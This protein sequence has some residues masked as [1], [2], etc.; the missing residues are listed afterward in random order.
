MSLRIL[1][2]RTTESNLESNAE[3]NNLLLGEPYLVTDKGQLAIGTGINTYF[4]VGGGSD[5]VGTKGT[6]NVAD[7]N[8]EWE[9][10]NIQLTAANLLKHKDMTGNAGL[11]LSSNTITHIVRLNSHD[12]TIQSNN[13]T[14]RTRQGHE[15][16]PTE[17]DHLVHKGFVL[18]EINKLPIHETWETATL[19]GDGTHTSTELLNLSANT[20]YAIRYILEGRSSF[21]TTRATFKYIMDLSVYRTSSQSYI[22]SVQIVSYTGVVITGVGGL[23]VSKDLKLGQIRIYPDMN[24]GVWLNRLRIE[25]QT[26]DPVLNSVDIQYRTIISNLDQ[27]KA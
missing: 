26:S 15:F 5:S 3:S 25:N 19:G 4:F 1:I 6:L 9:G 24:L 18:D 13:P 12:V 8:G 23:V 21:G 11:F 10:S 2:R 16:T 14:L 27:I 7:G 22:S 17:H 20:H